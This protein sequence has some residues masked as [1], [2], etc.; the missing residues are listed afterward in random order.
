MSALALQ[1]LADETGGQLIGESIPL[2]NLVIDSRRVG[3]GD[4]FAALKGQQVDG[5]DFAHNALQAG[6]SAL[7]TERRLDGLSPQLVVSNVTTA[8]GRFGYLKRQLFTGAVIA[9]TGSA[10]KTTSKNL[11]AAALSP[12]GSVHATSGNQN[13][14]LGV[15]MT[16]AA[17]SAAHQFGVIEMGAGQPGDIRY[18]CEIARPN[19]AV[20]LNASAAHLANYANVAA[21]A[22]TKGEIFEALGAEG[23]AIMNADQPWLSGWREQAGSARQV[24]FGLSQS[25]DYCARN[26][27]HG[28]IEGTRFEL[29]GPNCRE[30]VS[31]QLA[32]EQHVS[33]AL[34]AL[35]VA[36]ELG[37]APAQAAAAVASVAPAAGRG[38][39]SFRPG[40]GRV[41]D[42]SYNANPTAVRAA[43]DVLAREPG[44]R[45]M[46]LGPMMELGADSADYH[47]E[48][49]AYAKSAGLDQLLTV[50][51]EA[52][53]SAEAYGSG[54]QHFSDQRALCDGFPALPT[55][56]TI[57]VKGSRAAGLEA[58]VAWLLTS[59]EV[60]RC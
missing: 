49:G 40:G 60:P 54:A 38:A 34:A 45:L 37:V 47:R 2:R 18:L 3:E 33:N 31:L 26:I 15:P 20:C 59:E 41:V 46:V 4:L 48:I 29:Q 17:L 19:V 5:H 12:M 11:M 35:S 43:I 7:L 27:R 6:A 28:G 8:S 55:E 21:I 25:A 52:A 1:A 36:I 58:I 53:P 56:H 16:L 14:E 23:L 22:D 10:G 44:H 57:W 9:V 32:G 13:N 50:G 42:D 24:T 30:L 39:L 51:K